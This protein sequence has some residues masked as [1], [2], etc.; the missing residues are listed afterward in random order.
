MITISILDLGRRFNRGKSFVHTVLATKIPTPPPPNVPRP[1]TGYEP[2][3][4]GVGTNQII[5]ALRSV[6][7]RT[8]LYGGLNHM[9]TPKAQ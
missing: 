1:W 5:V 7:V 9:D 8:H 2:G 4:W 3:E 6:S